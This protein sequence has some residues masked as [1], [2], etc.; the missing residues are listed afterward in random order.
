MK[1]CT[2]NGCKGFSLV[3]MEMRTVQQLDLPRFE[4][5]GTEKTAEHVCNPDNIA[6]ANSSRNT[7]SCP[8]CNRRD[9]QNG[10]LFRCGAPVQNRSTG[11][12]EKL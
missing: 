1:K 11:T 5:R 7:R 3:S 6:T 8:N 12:P 10:G 4:V 2:F 9:I